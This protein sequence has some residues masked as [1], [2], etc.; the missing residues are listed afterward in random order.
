MN[1][2][3]VVPLRLDCE[4]GLREGCRYKARA[5]VG[6]EGSAVTAVTTDRQLGLEYRTLATCYLISPF[7]ACTN[8]SNY[9]HVPESVSDLSNPRFLAMK[10][11]LAFCFAVVLISAHALEKGKECERDNDLLYVPFLSNVWAHLTTQDV[12]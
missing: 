9:P 6:R 1:L 2:S 11:A 8:K 7:P 3:L 12:L 5:E 4:P 10:E